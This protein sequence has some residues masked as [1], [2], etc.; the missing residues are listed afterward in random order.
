[1]K[2]WQNLA[3]LEFLC[4]KRRKREATTLLNDA[5]KTDT[6]N[7]SQRADQN[8]AAAAEKNLRPCL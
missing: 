8:D 7:V 4:R 1:M 6:H 3:W 2:Q 5:K